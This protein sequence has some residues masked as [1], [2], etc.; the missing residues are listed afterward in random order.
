MPALHVVGY[1]DFFSRESVG[2][3]MLMQQAR[4]PQ[5]REQ[6]RLVLG[7]WDHGT[8]GKTTVAEVDF[9]PDAAVDTFALQLDWFDRRFTFGLGSPSKG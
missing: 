7:P 6:Q 3:F 1:Y 4:D 2:N 9:G 8:V 5:T